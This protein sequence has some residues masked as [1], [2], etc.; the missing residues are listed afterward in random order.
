MRIERIQNIFVNADQEVEVY[1]FEKMRLLVS[2]PDKGMC[3]K[4]KIADLSPVSMVSREH[5]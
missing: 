4:L 5:D 1:D 3:L 2:D